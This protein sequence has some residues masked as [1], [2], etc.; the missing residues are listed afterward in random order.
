LRELSSLHGN[1]RSQ[2]LYS[3]RK[4]DTQHSQRAL[5]YSG[6]RHTALARALFY[7]GKRHTALARALFYSEETH[8]THKSSILLGRD[9]QHS[10]ELYSAQQSRQKVGG[11]RYVEE[12]E[13]EEEERL[14]LHLE[15]RRQK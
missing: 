15:T 6:K 13:E 2:E 10:Q 12:E 8:S 5:F 9:T 14:Y 4:R 11:Q 1:C 3:A 7:S